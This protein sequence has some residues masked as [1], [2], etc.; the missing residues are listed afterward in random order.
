[1]DNLFFVSVGCLL[2]MYF[3]R[4]LT[5][6]LL[7]CGCSSGPRG[8]MRIGIDTKWYPINF[9]PQTALVNG[10]TEDLLL[11][12]ARYSG[13]QF[14]LITANWDTL[15]DG[16]RENKYDAILTS[17]PPYEYNTAKYDFSDNFLDL[18]PVLIVPVDSEA[19]DVS[20]MK[21]EMVGV[22][23]NDQTA[24]I[25]EKYPV[26]IRSYHSIPELLNALAAGEIQGALLSRIP[27]VNFVRDLYAG[28]LKIASA[29]LS[30]AGLHL[31]AS[32]GRMGTFN[33]TLEALR[34]RKTI[35]A[36]LKKWQLS[37]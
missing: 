30:D 13:V 5:L 29:P 28:K 35:D 24:L 33:K 3:L 1:M 2:N 20:G 8:T 18:G 17:M 7:L 31:A 23:I 19:L 12:M 26:I 11:E 14:E 25:L 34:K 27:A 4:L 16:L 36:L 37:V 15:T 9:G 32:K 22:I 21:G 10:Y 6:V